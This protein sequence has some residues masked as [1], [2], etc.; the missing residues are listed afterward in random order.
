MGK[1][2]ANIWKSLPDGE[3]EGYKQRASEAKAEYDQLNP[4]QPKQVRL[5]IICANC[6]AKWTQTATVL[7]D[8]G[9]RYGL[10]QH[11]TV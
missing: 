6:A 4:K 8:L 2:I 1:E 7:D 5:D 3:K 9:S 10:T 11:S